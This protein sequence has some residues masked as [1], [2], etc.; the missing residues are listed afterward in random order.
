MPIRIDSYR[1]P[2]VLTTRLLRFH[3]QYISQY[4]LEKNSR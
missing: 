1:N 3:G 4:L 2:E